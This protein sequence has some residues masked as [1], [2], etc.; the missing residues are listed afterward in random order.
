MVSFEHI[1]E[2]FKNYNFYYYTIPEQPYARLSPGQTTNHVFLQ[3]HVPN[4]QH[5]PNH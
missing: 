4:A 2:A 5:V 3:L 1:T